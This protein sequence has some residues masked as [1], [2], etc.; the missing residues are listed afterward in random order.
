[1]H[2]QNFISIYNTAKVHFYLYGQMGI[3]KHMYLSDTTLYKQYIQI[4]SYDHQV[5]LASC[6][7]ST[8]V[9]LQST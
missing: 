5:I 6:T 4:Q 7:C 3:Q 2:V 9:F 8:Q 1:M